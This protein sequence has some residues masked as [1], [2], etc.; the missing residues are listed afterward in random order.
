M[1]TP[2]ASPPLL[3]VDQ[4]SPPPPRARRDLLIGVP[5]VLILLCAVLICYLA[6]QSQLRMEAALLSLQVQTASHPP[7]AFIEAKPQPKPSPS[8]PVA[9]GGS[10]Q[11]TK[12]ASP[13]QEQASTGIQWSLLGPRLRDQLIAVETRDSQA[14]VREFFDPQGL[15]ERIPQGWFPAG[16]YESEFKQALLNEI[17]SSL[18]FLVDQIRQN[19]K[20]GGSYQFLGSAEKQLRVDLPASPGNSETVE[21]T[22]L[23]VLV[24]RMIRPNGNGVTYHDLVVKNPSPPSSG[25]PWPRI[26]DVYDYDA[27]ETLSISSARNVF[28]K[29]RDETIADADP[30]SQLLLLEART[31]QALSSRSSASSAAGGGSPNDQQAA[32]ATYR[33]MWRA[34]EEVTPN[35]R[36]RNAPAQNP[37]RD[38]RAFFPLL[39]LG[40][41]DRASECLE[42]LRQ[43]LGVQDSYLQVLDAALELAKARSET[44][45]D[46]MINLRAAANHALKGI[47]AAANDPAALRDASAQL[48]AVISAVAPSEESGLKREYDLLLAEARDLALARSTRPESDFRERVLGL[49][50]KPLSLRGAP[51]AKG[52]KESVA[53]L[54]KLID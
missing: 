52:F 25:S 54:P 17:E 18:I 29:P 3:P 41:R 32:E 10:A 34:Y 35:Y 19:L 24:F 11:A 21:W 37:A 20:S 13:S 1:S 33:E 28:G 49:L 50:Q 12:P 43:V 26:V 22:T 4:A 7:A 8:K 47:E 23:Q 48:L 9:E 46:P 44:S 42:H 6:Y 39:M 2:V 16:P 27:G 51:R 30:H 15:V 36:V 53:R 40:N 38:L 31:S 14:I 45:K 5:I